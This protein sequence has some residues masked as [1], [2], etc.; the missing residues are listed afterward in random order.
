MLGNHFDA[1][2]YGA[3]DPNSGTSILAEVGRAFASTVAT[4]WKPKRTLMFCAWDAE[5]NGL[6][7]STEF[8]QEF[9]EVLKDRAIIYINVDLISSNQSLDVRTTP[10][11][12]QSVVEVAKLVANPMESEQ[13]AGRKSV[14]DTWLKYFPSDTK[15]LPDYP[16]MIVPGGGSDHMSFLNFLGIPVVDMTYRNASWNS[17]PLYH[18]MYEVPYVNEHIFDVDNLAVHKAMAQYW[19]ELA[20]HYA[21]APVI[22]LNASTLARK[23]VEVYVSDI[24]VEVEGLKGKYPKEAEDARQQVSKLIKNAQDFLNVTQEFDANVAL[25]KI[26]GFLKDD[27]TVGRLNRRLQKLEQCFINPSLGLAAHNPEKR[28]VLYSLSGDDSYEARVMANVFDQVSA[29]KNAKTT[30]ERAKIGRQLAY[31]ITVVQYSIQCATKL[32]QTKI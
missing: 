19:A 22:P 6:I 10:T 15:W 9:A 20:R 30:E 12:Y 25:F 26:P 13:K 11:V 1:W 32:L 5:E 17:Y 29:F 28:H 3:I 24:K 23:L 7:G 31:Q 8:V 27:R 21:D 14:Y 4:G 18:S 2:V 16:K